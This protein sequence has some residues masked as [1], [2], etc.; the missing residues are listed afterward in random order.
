MENVKKKNFNVIFQHD[1]RGRFNPK[2]ENVFTFLPRN[3]RTST[4]KRNIHI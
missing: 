1:L 2:F 3:D 4:S